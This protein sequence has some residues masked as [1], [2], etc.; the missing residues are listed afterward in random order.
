MG[1]QKSTSR[2]N[3]KSCTH[4]ELCLESTPCKLQVTC[5]TGNVKRECEN[6]YVVTETAGVRRKLCI[7]LQSDSPVTR[8]LTCN[9]RV[10][11][12]VHDREIHPKSAVYWDKTWCCVHGTA[13]THDSHRSTEEVQF[14]QH[15]PFLHSYSM[16]AISCIE[17]IE[18]TPDLMQNIFSTSCNADTYSWVYRVTASPHWSQ[19]LMQCFH[20]V[21][22]QCFGLTDK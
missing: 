13:N 2:A 8:L 6:H 18:N 5:L 15:I 1:N 16:W 11:Q 21:R 22:M 20:T 4:L 9:W 14:I 3:R 19:Q 10:C 7:W 17:A 12:S